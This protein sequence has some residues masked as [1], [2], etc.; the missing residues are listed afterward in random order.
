MRKSQLIMAEEYDIKQFFEIKY[1]LAV[2]LQVN[3]ILIVVD[4]SPLNH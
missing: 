2:I 1:P 3:C 4:K